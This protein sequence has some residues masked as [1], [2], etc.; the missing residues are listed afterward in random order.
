MTMTMTVVVIWMRIDGIDGGNCDA[1][2]GY[3]SGNKGDNEDYNGDS[4]LE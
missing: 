2:D 4:I 3:G 1:Y